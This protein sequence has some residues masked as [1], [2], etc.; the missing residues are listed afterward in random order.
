MQTSRTIGGANAMT[1]PPTVGGIDI[2]KRPTMWTVD[3]SV[4][5][6]NADHGPARP[7][8]GFAGS[9]DEAKRLAVKARR[10]EWPGFGLCVRSVREVS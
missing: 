4:L 5:S 10:A 2:G 7:W 9:A 8:R 3:V 6:T 1:S